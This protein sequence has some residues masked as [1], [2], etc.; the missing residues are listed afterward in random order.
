MNQT[1]DIMIAINQNQLKTFKKER[2]NLAQVLAVSGN[3]WTK[4]D[5]STICETLLG[6]ETK[7]FKVFSKNWPWVRWTTSSGTW[8]REWVR[9]VRHCPSSKCSSRGLPSC[10]VFRSKQ[11]EAKVCIF[12]IMEFQ[13]LLA[14][15]HRVLLRFDSFFPIFWFLHLKKNFA[16]SWY[17]VF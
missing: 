11:P 17:L 14:F 10:L 1:Y 13:C 8:S 16:K 6:I 5:I 3:D 7:T 9:H 4:K 2:E 12:F 15:I